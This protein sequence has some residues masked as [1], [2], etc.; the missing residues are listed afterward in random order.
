M[1]TLREQYLRDLQAGLRD[2]YDQRVAVHK[3]FIAKLLPELTDI[4]SQAVAER[5]E[6]DRLQAMYSGLFYRSTL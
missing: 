2:A 3:A 4:E 1:S 6:R 5:I